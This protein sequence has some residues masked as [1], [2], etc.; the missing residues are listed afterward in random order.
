MASGVE[1]WVPKGKSYAKK[2]RD[3]ALDVTGYSEATRK[4]QLALRAAEEEQLKSTD[5]S[6]NR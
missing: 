5:K 2:V 6:I 3:T 4:A 1:A